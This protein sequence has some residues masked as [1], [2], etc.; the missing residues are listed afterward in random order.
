ML[1]D[2]FNAAIAKVNASGA[3]LAAAA[4]GLK[5]GLSAAQAQ[6]AI[7]SLNNTAS[8]LDEETAS[9]TAAAPANTP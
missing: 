8:T 9:L 4:S 2:D 3:K 1:I 5:G 6:T 7:N